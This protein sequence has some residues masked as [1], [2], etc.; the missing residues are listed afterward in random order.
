MNCQL[1]S[2]WRLS[3][4]KPGVVPD[5]EGLVEAAGESNEVRCVGLR[6]RVGIGTGEGDGALVV[7]FGDEGLREE[8]VGFREGGSSDIREG[9]GYAL[10]KGVGCGVGSGGEESS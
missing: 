10:G 7:N 8:A 6:W 1:Y 5:G 3:K 4:R 2:G 9:G